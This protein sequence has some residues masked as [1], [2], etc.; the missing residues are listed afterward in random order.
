M[1]FRHHQTTGFFRGKNFVFDPR[2]A[3]PSKD[4]QKDI[5]GHCLSCNALFDDYS[6][7]YR[8]AKCRTLVLICSPCDARLKETSS[9]TTPT[10]D[11]NKVK[12]ELVCT[13]CQMN[14]ET[15]KIVSKNR[16]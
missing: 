11:V 13:S 9:P 1:S 14:L 10:S 16:T 3:L 5:I 2:I 8:C 12:E 4:N 7:Q 15:N 6:N